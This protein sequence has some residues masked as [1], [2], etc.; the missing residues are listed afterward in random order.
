M[1]LNEINDPKSLGAALE[2][3][4][5]T[6][7]RKPERAPDPEADA[8]AESFRATQDA[9]RLHAEELVQKYTKD[10][11]QQFMQ[12]VKQQ[13]PGIEKF[14]DLNHVW[15]FSPAV[16]ADRAAGLNPDDEWKAH[17]PLP[18]SNYTGD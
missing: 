1:K 18:G 3:L 4:K 8:R 17:Q 16:K 15:M 14:V 12:D 2:K 5:A 10:Q 7:G 6:Y 9:Y 13:F 11:E